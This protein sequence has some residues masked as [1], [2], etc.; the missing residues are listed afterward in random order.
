[1]Y[2]FCRYQLTVVGQLVSLMT[3]SDAAVDTVLVY[4]MKQMSKFLT[5]G[6]EAECNEELVLATILTALKV[7]ET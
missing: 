5:S 4:C 6:C 2:V 1:M 3:E 7:S